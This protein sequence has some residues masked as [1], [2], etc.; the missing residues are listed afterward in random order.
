[1]ISIGYCKKDRKCLKINQANEFIA[2]ASVSVKESWQLGRW[3]CSVA[4]LWV[5]CMQQLVTLAWLTILL[6]IVWMTGC[7][8]VL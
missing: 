1:M 4:P 2:G 3:E 8:N 5:K 6:K 7:E